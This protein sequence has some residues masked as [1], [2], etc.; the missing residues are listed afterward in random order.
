MGLLG[1]LGIFSIVL[2]IVWLF[3]GGGMSRG[4]FRRGGTA[5]SG[6]VSFILIVIGLMMITAD[7]TSPIF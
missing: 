6:P 5:I 4:S 7:I 2:G 1:T 3:L